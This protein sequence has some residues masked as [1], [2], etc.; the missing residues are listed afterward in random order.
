MW[1]EQSDDRA[2][3]GGGKK[4]SKRWAQAWGG[5]RGKRGTERVQ[6]WAE[7]GLGEGGGEQA[8][9]GACR[10]HEESGVPLAF[11]ETAVTT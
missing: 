8:G 4:S 7:A 11:R 2:G 5:A 3:E 1:P 6:G 9:V 10:S